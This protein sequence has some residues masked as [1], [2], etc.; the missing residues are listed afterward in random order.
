MLN[1]SNS[2]DLPTGTVIRQDRD[3]W[4]FVL[5]NGTKRR[6]SVIVGWDGVTVLQ[7]DMTK[8]A[9]VEV[10]VSKSQLVY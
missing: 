3:G 2:E 5:P 7:T 1:Q 8:H 4:Y 10:S 9:A 6:R